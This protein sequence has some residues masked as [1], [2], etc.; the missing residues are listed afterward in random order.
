MFCINCGAELKNDS[1]FCSVCGA[2]V[3]DEP[4]N[5]NSTKDNLINEEAGNTTNNVAE[6]D[7]DNTTNNSVDNAISNKP[8]KKSS[9]P[10][11]LT[12]SILALI[13]LAVL[14]IVIFNAN[15]KPS[16]TDSTDISSMASEVVD[17]E[18]QYSDSSDKDYADDSYEEYAEDE[19]LEDEH[20]DNNLSD[21]SDFDNSNSENQAEY[22][23]VPSIAE[24]Y[25]FDELN[26]DEEVAEETEELDEPDETVESKLVTDL[27][28][29]AS[30]TCQSTSV[31][32]QTYDATN[33]IDG[34]YQTAWLEGV[35]GTGEG[36][37]ITFNFGRREIIDRIE[38][39][40][41]FMN[42]M[43]RYAINGKVKKLL[44]E[45]DNGIRDIVEVGIMDVP[46]VK[47]PF[48]DGEYHPTVIRFSYPEETSSIKITILEAV[49]GSKYDDTAISEIKLYSR[50]P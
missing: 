1:K 11:I 12:G 7:A 22:A 20:T 25:E 21:D 4:L 28:V 37:S 44:I 10:F 34:N 31:D 47:E 19:N 13:I 27:W 30:S 8:T 17:S 39:Y 9:V 6:N 35:N 48:S 32:G 14:F 16:K 24:T 49:P 18:D 2:Q 45:Y 38:I 43:Y 3:L 15:K 41:G 42:T 50:M 26:Y 5:D 33:L 46:E 29:S 40:N 23:P 36:E